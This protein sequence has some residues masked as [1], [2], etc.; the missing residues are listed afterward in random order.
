MSAF[1]GVI[2]MSLGV[3]SEYLAIT[4][5]I[6]MGRPLYVVSSKP[7]RPGISR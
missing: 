1:S 5:G 7:T 2:L 6:A 3:I 4:L